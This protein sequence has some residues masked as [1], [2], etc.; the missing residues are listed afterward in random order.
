MKMT[1][2]QIEAYERDGFLT[3]LKAVDGVLHPAIG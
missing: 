2:Q 1:K 3:G